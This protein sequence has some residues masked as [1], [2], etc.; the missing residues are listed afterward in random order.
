MHLTNAYIPH[1]HNHFPPPC[2]FCVLMQGDEGEEG[3]EGPDRPTEPSCKAKATAS[4]KAKR[5]PPEALTTEGDE[6]PV[7]PPP[8]LPRQP[9]QPP[10]P[11]PAD[12][13]KLTPRETPAKPKPPANPPPAEIRRRI[14][15]RQLADAAAERRQLEQQVLQFGERLDASQAQQ[16]ADAA[17]GAHGAVDDGYEDVDLHLHPD[18]ALARGTGQHDVIA[19]DAARGKGQPDVIADI[20]AV[21]DSHDPVFNRWTAPVMESPDGFSA[22]YSGLLE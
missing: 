2:S 17:A 15:A 9:P 20:G 14:E 5:R 13:L 8:Q 3:E 12:K 7:E 22:H 11:P 21:D 16:V 6:A 19:D 4:S 1:A 18:A 10:D